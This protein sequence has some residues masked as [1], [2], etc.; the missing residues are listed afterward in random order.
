MYLIY[1]KLKK[2][3]SSKCLFCDDFSMEGSGLCE[4]CC[5]YKFIVKKKKKIK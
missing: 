1:K 2:R 4:I 3:S 5:Y